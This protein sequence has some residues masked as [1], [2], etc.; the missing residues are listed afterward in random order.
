MMRIFELRKSLFALKLV[1]MALAAA[2][3]AMESV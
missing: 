1:L 3:A 2:D